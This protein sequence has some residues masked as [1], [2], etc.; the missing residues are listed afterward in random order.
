[1]T[2]SE[3]IDIALSQGD[4]VPETD[5]GYIARRR[6]ALNF[7]REVVHDIWWQRDWPWKKTQAD[8]TVLVNET[9]V[10]VPSNFDSI[11]NYGGVYRLEGGLHYYPPLELVPESVVMESRAGSHTTSIPRIFALFGQDPNT[12]VDLIQV[13]I[14]SANLGLRLF[15]QKQPPR[16]LDYGD[17]DQP[18]LTLAA[19]ALTR[20][21][22]IASVV[23][24]TA[25][26]FQTFDRVIVA[27]ANEAA[28]NGT[29]QVI[30]T[31]VLTFT[32]T[33]V[34]LPATPATTATSI[35][36]VPDVA[37]ANAALNEVPQRF[38]LKVVLN[39]LKAKLR[40]SKGD[41][42]WQKLVTDYAA[43]IEDMKRELARFQGEIR[44]LPSFFGDH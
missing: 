9:S 22:Q 38:H 32:Y 23:T 3:L 25:H 10:A 31:G 24:P 18:A 4:N 43:G 2:V 41:A 8:V 44:Q 5:A 20:S 28:Y 13:P 39:G 19:G 40:E 11:G 16:L 27:G 7:L 26:G 37:T 15:Y 17:P 14:A 33:V 1:V 35:T 21:G 36:V 42:R 12:F 6:R 34:G 30:V 29:F